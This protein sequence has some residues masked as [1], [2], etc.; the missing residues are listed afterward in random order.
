MGALRR[1]NNMAMALEARGFGMGARPTS[2]GAYQPHPRDRIAFA[3]LLAIGAIYF[4]IYL[5]G[6]G[7]IAP[8]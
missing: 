2:L 4:V 1:V 8:R 6:Y 3:I 5:K 7:T